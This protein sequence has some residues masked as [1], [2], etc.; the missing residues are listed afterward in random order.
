MKKSALPRYQ[1][2]IMQWCNDL[3]RFDSHALLCSIYYSET[4]QRVIRFALKNSRS[5]KVSEKKAVIYVSTDFDTNLI[6]DLTSLSANI[7]FEHIENDPL[8]EDLIDVNRL[9]E[10]LQRD[11]N[12]AEVYPAIVIANIGKTICFLYS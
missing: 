8:Q 5:N 7:K 12:D 11:S 1:E 6:A 2:E 3:F 9:E 4:F 10:I